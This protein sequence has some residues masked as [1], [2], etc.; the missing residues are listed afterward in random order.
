MKINGITIPHPVTFTKKKPTE[1]RAGATPT[2]SVKRTVIHKPASPKAKYAMP[3]VAVVAAVATF[4]AGAAIATAAGATIAAMV[5]GGAMM[6]GAAATVVGTVTGNK[7]LV[8][9]GGILSAVGGIGAIG[10]RDRKS[11][12]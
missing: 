4:S 8:K 2:F 1:S 11:V 7:N 3:F 10:L 12:V 5:A 6:V 9:Y